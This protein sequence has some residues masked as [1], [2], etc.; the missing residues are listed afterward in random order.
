MANLK[1]ENLSGASKDRL[2]EAEV[3]LHLSKIILEILETDKFIECVALVDAEFT[4]DELASHTDSSF[5][6]P[7]DD[8][9]DEQLDPF[10]DELLAKT[11]EN[12]NGHSLNFLTC[13]WL[14]ERTG[15]EFIKYF[16]G[17]KLSEEASEAIAECVEAESKPLE[18]AAGLHTYSKNKSFESRQMKKKQKTG[19]GPVGDRP[20]GKLSREQITEVWSII[21]D[22]RAKVKSG[23]RKKEP[24]ENAINFLKARSG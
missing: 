22:H 4:K 11:G 6:L 14:Q 24:I 1:F 3:H 13:Y 15:T 8:L 12:A 5:E 17:N 10:R 9:D 20:M 21:D 7:I 16:R 19:D 18:K 2:F 23:L